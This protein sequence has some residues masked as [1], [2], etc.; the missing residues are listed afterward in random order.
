MKNVG[1]KIVF[2]LVLRV[3][4]GNLERHMLR[5]VYQW[6]YLV[7]G[8]EESLSSSNGLNRSN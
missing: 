5:G 8:F 6:V 7:E 2:V 3:K 4:Y 1:R